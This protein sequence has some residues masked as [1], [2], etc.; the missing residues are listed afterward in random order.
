MGLFFPADTLTC[1]GEKSTG[2]MNLLNDGSA[3]FSGQLV[4]I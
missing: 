3:P 1:H 4:L 2:D